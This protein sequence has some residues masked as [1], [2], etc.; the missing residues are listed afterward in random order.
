M[1]DVFFGREKEEV[2]LSKIKVSKLGA[3]D[4]ST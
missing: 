2:D 3:V 1:V 4:R